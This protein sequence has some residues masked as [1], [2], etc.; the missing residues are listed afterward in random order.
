MTDSTSTIDNRPGMMQFPCDCRGLSSSL[1]RCRHCKS[2]FKD[3]LQHLLL[4]KHPR[5]AAGSPRHCPK[6]WEAAGIGTLGIG[7]HV[8]LR[9]FL[10]STPNRQLD[11]PVNETRPRRTVELVRVKNQLRLRCSMS[12]A[13]KI[14]EFGN[15]VVVE[16]CVL[17]YD[18]REFPQ[19]IHRSG[20]IPVDE[21]NR[22]ATS[23]QNV[24]R[25][26]VAVAND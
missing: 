19:W 11:H 10:A 23:R 13:G 21:S 2:R 9:C 24:P 14:I 20:V 4:V 7:Y 8:V 17:P 26:E 25:S 18:V 12:C 15:V 5:G 6:N 22:L 16:L 1:G 3:V